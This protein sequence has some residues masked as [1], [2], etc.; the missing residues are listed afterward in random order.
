M[1]VDARFVS[2]VRRTSIEVYREIEA[3]GLLTERRFE[4]YR[5]LFHNGPATGGEVIVGISP[6]ARGSVL[7][8]AR[9]RLNELRE[10]GVVEELGTTICRVTG[11]EVI[12]W[13]VTDHLPVEPLGRVKGPTRKQ[14]IEEIR[15]LRAENSNLRQKVGRLKIEQAQGRLFDRGDA[16]PWPPR[17]VIGRLVDAA[18]HLLN[19]HNCDAHGYEE[20]IESV[21]AAEEWLG[22]GG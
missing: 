7:S 18:K 19:D 11:H 1:D 14:L 15:R 2:R 13:D 8:Q 9:A 10:R 17:D 20:V 21:R 3:N 5:W 22:R 6:Q 12:L 16:A 4:V